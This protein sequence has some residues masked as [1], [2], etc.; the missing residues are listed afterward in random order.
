MTPPPTVLATL[1]PTMLAGSNLAIDSAFLYFTTSSA[2]MR[3]PLAGGA[4]VQI[5]AGMRGPLVLG[6]NDVYGFDATGIVSVPK[7]GGTLASV[8]KG[9]QLG[10]YL[11]IDATHLYFH[12]YF[13]V[14][15]NG[16]NYHQS[17]FQLEL[18]TATV[19]SIATNQFVTGPFVGDDVHLYWFSD[20]QPVGDVKLMSLT[21]SDGATTVLT[22]GVGNPDG[23]AFDGANL[24]WTTWGGWTRPPPPSALRALP[25]SGGT[26]ALLASPDQPGDLAVDAKNIY[27]TV[28]DDT[29]VKLPTTGGMPTALATQLKR[30][31][32][33]VLDDTSVY[34]LNAGD[35]TIVKTSK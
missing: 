4:P 24:Y 31:R 16:D 25:A 10:E 28:Q 18:A 2:A 29:I 20:D 13:G 3:L 19:T 14:R 7:T 34:W 27:L 21:K 15:T 1:D 5:A 35:G 26:P 32:A 22:A 6:A 33:L 30:P 12:D 17:I 8:H 11:A 9:S 23:P